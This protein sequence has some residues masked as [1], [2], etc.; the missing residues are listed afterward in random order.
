[1]SENIR[2]RVYVTGRVQGVFFRSETRNEARRQGV[3][4]WVKNLAD[5]R[6]EAVF[7]GPKDKVEAMVDWCHHGPS[8]ARVENVE[9]REE[10]Y[11]GEFSGFS[12]RH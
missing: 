12:V 5:G 8:M 4:G 2:R 1:M 10:T 11:T 7:E 9:A 6:V 3:D